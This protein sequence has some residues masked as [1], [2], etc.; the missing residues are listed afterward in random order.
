MVTFVCISY[1][2]KKKY[3]LYVLYISNTHWVRLFRLSQHIPFINKYI[4]RLEIPFTRSFSER[5]FQ[6]QTTLCSIFQMRRAMLEWWQKGIIAQISKLTCP[7][8]T[9]PSHINCEMDRQ[10]HQLW[11]RN[12]SSLSTSIEKFTDGEPIAGQLFC[13]NIYRHYQIAQNS[14][15]KLNHNCCMHL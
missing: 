11:I 14:V 3:T 6:L 12:S 4:K 13:Q 7:W 1:T 9:S 10:L 2:E 8:R 5:V 15:L